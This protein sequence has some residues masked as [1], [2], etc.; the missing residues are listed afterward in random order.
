MRFEMPQDPS[1]RLHKIGDAL[2]QLLNVSNPLWDHTDTTPNESTSG[3]AYRCGWQLEQLID[4]IFGRGHC[5]SAHH[6][7]LERAHHLLQ[8]Y[9]VDTERLR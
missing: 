3:R 5:A 6:K 8:Q 1:P 4:A 9:P 7:D 2:S